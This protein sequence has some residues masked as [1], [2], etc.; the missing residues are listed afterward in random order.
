MMIRKK[1]TSNEVV[2]EDNADQPE[3]QVETVSKCNERSS[4]VLQVKRGDRRRQAA[5][6]TYSEMER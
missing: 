2:V 1:G 6:E 3:V 5:R 4:L